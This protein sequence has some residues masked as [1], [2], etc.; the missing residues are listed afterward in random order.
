MAKKVVLG[1]FEPTISSV[2]VSVPDENDGELRVLADYSEKSIKGQETDPF[3][4]NELNM[5]LTVE[6]DMDELAQSIAYLRDQTD[7]KVSATD[8]IKSMLN[9]SGEILGDDVFNITIEC[10]KAA[11]RGSGDSCIDNICK[12]LEGLLNEYKR[13]F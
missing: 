10:L 3:N 11:R 1:H 13:Y 6:M 8:V 5:G 2:K 9:K 7:G 4:E 12:G